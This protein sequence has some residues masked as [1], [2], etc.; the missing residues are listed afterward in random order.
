MKVVWHILGVN[1]NVPLGS[2]LDSLLFLIYINDIFDEIGT[3]FR[4]F[5][6]DTFLFMIV[7]DPGSVPDM[8]SRECI[9][10]PL[11]GQSVAS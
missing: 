2:I 3:C 10:N 9:K 5:A 6:D 11:L 1:A 4:L 8:M 7:E